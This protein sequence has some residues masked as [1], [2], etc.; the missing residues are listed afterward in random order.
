MV[1]VIHFYTWLTSVTSLPLAFWVRLPSILADI[2]TLTVLWRLTFCKNSLFARV[3]SWKLLF[4]A[5][6]PFSILIF[7][8][9]GNTDAVMMFFVMLSIYL[10]QSQKPAWVVGIAFGMAMNIKIVPLFFVPVFLLVLQA[11]RRQIEYSMSTI[12]TGVI[13]GMPYLAQDPQFILSRVFGYGGQYNNW[14]LSR[15]LTLMSPELPW[16]NAAFEGAGKYVLLL[17]VIALSLWMNW[18]QNDSRNVPIETQCAV[19]V[20]AF[21]A[22]TPAFGYQYLTW[23]VPFLP[24]WNWRASSLFTL[25]G[26][27]YLLSVYTFRWRTWNWYANTPWLANNWKEHIVIFETLTWC[28]VLVL[29]YLALKQVA[30]QRSLSV[31]DGSSFQE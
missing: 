6:S 7:G 16:L 15:L 25:C 20:A 8:F 31:S 29:F 19:V 18:R 11:P 5:A 23:I 24:L 1:H 30:Q 22:L 12:A 2:G 14:G 3:S 27:L 10:L 17:V 26:T 28:S 9:H 13:G 21:L 4:V